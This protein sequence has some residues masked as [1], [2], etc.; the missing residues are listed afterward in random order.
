MGKRSTEPE[1]QP[2]LGGNESA[3]SDQAK[4]LEELGFWIEAPTGVVSSIDRF[5]SRG[6]EHSEVLKG[7]G[8]GRE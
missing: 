2:S 1:R 6:G 7:E 5:L 8:M 4:G 3:W